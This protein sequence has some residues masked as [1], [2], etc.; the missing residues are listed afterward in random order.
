MKK[1]KKKGKGKIVTVLR[2]SGGSAKNSRDYAN[3]VKNCLPGQLLGDK[4]LAESLRL[5]LEPW[6]NAAHEIDA[7]SKHVQ[8][9]RNTFIKIMLSLDKDV[10]LSPRQLDYAMDRYLYHLSVPAYVTAPNASGKKLAK[11]ERQQHRDLR[12]QIAEFTTHDNTDNVH[13]HGDM[14]MVDKLTGQVIVINDGF[15]KYASEYARQET[16]LDLG[17]LPLTESPR[18]VV[19]KINGLTRVEDT[20]EDAKDQKKDQVA[21][22]AMEETAEETM[23][24]M[25]EV[26]L[27][28]PLDPLPKTAAQFHRGRQH[29]GEA[30]RKM[31]AEAY[32]DG[33]PPPLPSIPDTENFTDPAHL[34]ALKERLTRAEKARADFEALL[35]KNNM[36]IRT[37]RKSGL[38]LCAHGEHAAMFDV[39]RG[40]D[41]RWTRMAIEKFTW[42]KGRWEIGLPAKEQDVSLGRKSSV[43]FMTYRMW[44]ARQKYPEWYAKSLDPHSLP[45]VD[46]SVEVRQ[47]NGQT[48]RPGRMPLEALKSLADD[49][50][51]NS[52]EGTV[53]QDMEAA[54][55]GQV[56]AC[57]LT[58]RPCMRNGEMLLAIHGIPKARLDEFKQRY[59]PALVLRVETGFYT[60]VLNLHYD[61]Q[62]RWPARNARARVGNDIVQEFG[63]GGWSDGFLMPEVPGLLGDGW[64]FPRVTRP[65]HLRV[66]EAAQ[67]AMAEAWQKLVAEEK[68][69]WIKV[70]E[71][72]EK[73]QGLRSG[74]ITGNLAGKLHREGLRRGGPKAPDKAGPILEIARS[75]EAVRVLTPGGGAGSSKNDR[76]AEDKAEQKK[77]TPQPQNPVPMLRPNDDEDEKKKK[78]K[79]RE[80]QKQEQQEQQGPVR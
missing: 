52:C 16:M 28:E 57:T 22:E 1:D 5:N 8:E 14:S 68:A 4:V 48:Q 3:D 49:Y 51:N 58:V 35:I 71:I 53:A 15:W 41:P 33:P 32:P 46:Y 17:M 25:I 65:S 80:K 12:D 64:V 44:V 7:A 21:Q 31:V 18:Y 67:T 60:A 50:L 47:L 55:L 76:R 40:F 42:L 56:P 61:P 6:Q 11:T 39:T 62:Q 69:W 45:W 2:P 27:D 30:F 23:R 34:Q 74:A 54:K 36:S 72:A 10:I 24:E 77:T 79:L 19:R 66:S 20:E 75:I 70:A 9:G 26:D 78:R 73:R 38:V 37:G 59:D 43:E 63:A 29:P 13:V